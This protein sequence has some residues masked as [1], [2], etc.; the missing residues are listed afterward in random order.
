MCRLLLAVL[1]PTTI[2]VRSKR[3][4]AFTLRGSG[5]AGLPIAIQHMV[6][7]LPQSQLVEV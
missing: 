3:C 4:L 6:S 7:P 1:S 2:D 5:L